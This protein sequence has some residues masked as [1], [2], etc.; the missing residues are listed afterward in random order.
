MNLETAII[1][2]EQ[3]LLIFTEFRINLIQ[4]RIKKNLLSQ[5]V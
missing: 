2:L 3:A 5:A 4:I 1:E